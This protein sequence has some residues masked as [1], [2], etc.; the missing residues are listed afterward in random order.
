MTPRPSD[1][2][3]S[4]P[5]VPESADGNN[6]AGT[7]AERIIEKFGGIRP[8]AHKLEVPVTTVQ[9]WKKRGAIPSARHPDLLAAAS[10]YNITVDQAE[11]DA[12]APADERGAE[13]AAAV[14]PASAIPVYEASAPAD[15][16]A[17][18]TPAVT[19]GPADAEPDRPAAPVAATAEP[20]PSSG[21]RGLAT[22]AIL[23]ALAG[24]GAAV[25]APLW[26]PQVLP[27]IWGPRNG[28]QDPLQQRLADLEQRVGQNASTVE[29]LSRRPAASADGSAGAGVDPAQ[30]QP[31]ADRISALEQGAQPAIDPAQL[32]SLADRI[33]ALEQRPQ[34]Q[35]GIDRAGLDQRLIPIEQQLLAIAQVREQIQSLSGQVG[36]QLQSLNNRT[37][38]LE[39]EAGTARQLSQS[40]VG[41]EQEAN[42]LSQEIVGV[43]SRTAEMAQTLTRQQRAET[44]AQALVL[45]ST[46]LRAALQTPQPFTTE[47]SA[48]RSLGIDDPKL[49]DALSAI[50]P[51]A[52]TGIPTESQLRD[53]YS[54][55]AGEIVRTSVVSQG[56]QWWDQALARAGSVV[57]VR[58]VAGDIEGSGADAIVGRAE[59]RLKEGK[60]QAAVQELESLSGDAAHAAQPWLRDA[61]ARVAANQ[62][63]ALT[64]GQAIA[65][66]AGAAN[67]GKSGGEAQ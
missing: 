22:L 45:A 23:L 21:G 51:F 48:V 67:G 14:E 35:P 3:D 24:T 56:G 60:L 5:T 66:L 6:P 18:A 9:G 46:Q 8:M 25:T 2:P 53:R 28:G 30:I 63:A 37:A 61:K 26:G 64:T 41:L 12:A 54:D 65:R 7:A 32:Q 40:I 47:L 34:P 58:R 17:D 11:L 20:A 15:A 27:N 42:R 43:N 4:D 50:E 52:G 16:D 19:T 36:Q 55:I 49:S 57:N 62:A 59:A 31:L 38:A 13:D 39:Q 10:R 44:A 1:Q 29:Q 33:S